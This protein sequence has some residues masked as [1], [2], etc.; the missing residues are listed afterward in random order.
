MINDPKFNTAK[1]W[2]EKL[3]NNIIQ[4]IES[5]DNNKFDIRDL[6]LASNVVII[7]E[8][9]EDILSKKSLE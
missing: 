2:F 3:R 1:D 7:I 9:I 6:E 4:T 8:L 5:I